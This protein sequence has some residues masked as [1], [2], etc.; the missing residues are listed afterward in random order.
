MW[1]CEPKSCRNLPRYL[2]LGFIYSR[3]PCSETPEAPCKP[4]GVLGICM[5]Q[6]YIPGKIFESEAAWHY[7]WPLPANATSHPPARRLSTCLN[8]FRSTLHGSWPF[9]LPAPLHHEIW[10]Y[11]KCTSKVHAQVLHNLMVRSMEGRQLCSYLWPPW[12][13]LTQIHS[14]ESHWA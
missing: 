6:E 8:A 7:P 5:Q 11:Y 2:I 14:C 3:M 9:C 12:D 13:A 1:R 10:K 4:C